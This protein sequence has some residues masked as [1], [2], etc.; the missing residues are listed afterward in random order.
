MHKLVLLRHGQSTWNLENRFTGWTDVDLTPQGHA[1]AHTAAR[2]LKD[3]GYTFDLAYTSVLK[4]AIRTLWVVLDDMDL[5]WI[6]VHRDWR[7]NERHYGA[8]QGLNKAE[9]AAKYGEDQV[10]VWRRSYATPPPALE[11]NDA[12][13]PGSDPRYAG[14]APAELPVTESLSDTVLRFLPA[15]HGSIAPLVSAGKRVIIAAH[16]N[17]LRALVKY[18]DG[19]SD[20]AIVELNIPTGIPL[21][22]ELDGGL[23]PIRHY[24]LGDANAVKLAAQAVAA[25]GRKSS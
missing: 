15:W 25:Q 18:L 14:L 5:M 3:G 12:R 13:F 6:P 22:Y 17:S 16:G 11:R 10:K 19:V 21:V 23:K 1:E 9:T 20:E 4:R 7:L 24:Y 2:A 8:L